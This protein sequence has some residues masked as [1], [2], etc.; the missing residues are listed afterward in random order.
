MKLSLHKDDTYQ[1]TM[2]KII[3]MKDFV[4]KTVDKL[5]DKNKNKII[6]LKK[7]NNEIKDIIYKI[8]SLSELVII[9]IN[10]KHIFHINDR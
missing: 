5:N 3:S 8:E 10:V 7:K 2:S 9:E 1:E 6:K 4:D